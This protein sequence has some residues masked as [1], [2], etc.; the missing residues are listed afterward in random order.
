MRNRRTKTNIL[1]ETDRLWQAWRSP[2]I[3]E[4]ILDSLSDGITVVNLDLNYVKVNDAWLRIHGFTDKTEMLGKN[5]F[6]LVAPCDLQRV[7]STATTTIEI[8]TTRGIELNLLR[9]DGSQFPAEVAISAVRNKSGT[10]IGFVAVTRDMAMYKRAEDELRALNR[11]LV[12][13]RE[14][15]RRTIGRE[16]HDQIGQSLTALKIALART[17]MSVSPAGRPVLAT[18]LSLV[19]E[20]I[21]KVRDLSL[22]L[23]PSMLDELGL[24]P[25][26]LWHF[27]RF[28]DQVKVRVNFEHGRMD[29]TLSPEV[30]IAAFR[31]VQEALTNVARHARVEEVKVRLWADGGKL[32]LLVEDEGIGFDPEKLPAGTSCGFRGM[33]ERAFS[34]GGRVTVESVPG[35]GTTLIAELPIPHDRRD[36]Q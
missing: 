33:R 11:R 4:A 23:W 21:T 32:L 1:N 9:K 36:G 27:D 2:E 25:A 29:M 3:L 19:E 6:E 22:E 16:L 15:E 14:E 35:S 12:Q 10:P 24:L 18:S 7:Q 20:L 26:L 28:T 31:I 34:V 5:A 17:T 13:I 30:K 8:G